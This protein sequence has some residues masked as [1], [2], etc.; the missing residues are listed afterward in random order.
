MVT[1]LYG[2]Y[3]EAVC[4][5]SFGHCNFPGACCGNATAPTGELYN[6]IRTE[7]ADLIFCGTYLC[8]TV[9]AMYD[10]GASE[11]L[12]GVTNVARRNHAWV[13]FENFKCL[14][15]SGSS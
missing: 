12:D 3:D 6:G 11:T 9:Y 13:A 8:D 1:G 7:I 10:L 5:S 15:E 4:K 2:N 14:P